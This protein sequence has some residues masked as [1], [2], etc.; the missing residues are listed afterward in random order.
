MYVLS[1]PFAWTT[2]NTLQLRCLMKRV[3]AELSNT[4]HCTYGQLFVLHC[5]S[6]YHSDKD[7]SLLWGSSR[8]RPKGKNHKFWYLIGYTLPNQLEMQTWGKKWFF[9]FCYFF[10]FFSLQASELFSLGSIGLTPK[11]L[12]SPNNIDY[13]CIKH[14]YVPYEDILKNIFWLHFEKLITDKWTR[15]LWISPMSWCYS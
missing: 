1:T 6:N 9:C 13:E 5:A 15:P 11:K 10:M 4:I 7:S 3:R 2:P 8:R 12:F 14:I